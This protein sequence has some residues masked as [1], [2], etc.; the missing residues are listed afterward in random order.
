M[1]KNKK[2]VKNQPAVFTERQDITLILYAC[3]TIMI[4]VP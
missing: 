3:D 1:I 2:K 4:L